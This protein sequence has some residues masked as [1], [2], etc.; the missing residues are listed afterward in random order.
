[1]PFDEKDCLRSWN[2]ETGLAESFE[3]YLGLL[4]KHDFSKKGFQ[5]FFGADKLQKFFPLAKEA[6]V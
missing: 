6:Q 3:A 1:M 4:N 5:L 2:D